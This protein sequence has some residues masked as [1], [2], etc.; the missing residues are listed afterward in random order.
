MNDNLNP[1]GTI[2]VDGEDMQVWLPDGLTLDLVLDDDLW[3]GS[4]DEGDDVPF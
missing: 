1:A 3:G 2:L 4:G